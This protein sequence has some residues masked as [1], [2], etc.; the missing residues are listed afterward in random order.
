MAL[1]N[2]LKL[3]SRA[4]MGRALMAT[5]IPN[6]TFNWVAE[7][8]SITFGLGGQ[9]SYPFVALAGLPGA[10]LNTTAANFSADTPVTGGGHV[11]LTDIATSG[12]SALTID[13]NYSTRAGASFD[14]TKNVNLLSLLI[15]TN[16]SGASD[17]TALQK[18]LLIRDYFRKAEVTGYQLRYLYSEIARNDPVFWPGTLIPLNTL[19]QTY[20]NSDLRCH[21]YTNFAADNRFNSVAAAQD[22]TYYA[23]DGVHPNVLGEA[24]MGALALPGLL[25]VLST[26]GA[27]LQIP[28]FSPLDGPSATYSNGNRTL[29]GSTTC[30]GSLIWKKTGKWAVQFSADTVSG[31]SNVFGV[32]I[33]DENFEFSVKTL[34]NSTHGIAYRNDGKIF[35]NG[36]QVGS[37]FDTYTT[38]DQID[39]CYDADAKLLYFR[40]NRGGVTGNWN[41]SAPANPATGVG[42]IDV[43][44]FS[45]TYIHPAAQLNTCQCT[46]N[47]AASQFVN[48]TPPSGF[49]AAA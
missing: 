33:A 13:Q 32:G 7:G 9:P 29:N 16:T 42:G 3:S 8:D 19:L 28:T 23:A 24:T 4:A 39:M 5:A 36:I 11:Y 6:Q 41:G 2:N 12:I 40:R 47:F 27:L 43:S 49:S 15:G 30:T 25:G 1:A 18:Y 48:F 44:S 17:T 35:R 34:D 37:T 22:T 10:T 26:P 20:F 45:A 14:G 46:S 31:S 21:G 38:G